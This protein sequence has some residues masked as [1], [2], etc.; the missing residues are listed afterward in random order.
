M[1]PRLGT[2]F[3]AIV[4]GAPIPAAFIACSNTP[5]A[6]DA[7]GVDADATLV[8]T[9]AASEDVTEDTYV[10]WC[11][12]GPPRQ[13]G[14]AGCDEFFYVPCGLP[15]GFSV[16]D[17]GVVNHCSLICVDASADDCAVLPP[18]WI[19]YFLDAGFIDAATADTVDAGAV[20][21]LCVCLSG[22]GR[23]PEGFRIRPARTTSALAGYFSQMARLEHAS[24][25]AFERMERELRGLAAPRSLLERTA[26]AAR[27]ERVHA[28]SMTRLARRFGGRVRLP[29]R[30]REL[31][32]RT[33]LAIAR[34]NLVEGCI[35][36]TYGALVMT[37]QAAHAKDAHVRRALTPIAL[38]ETRHAELSWAVAA[39]LDGALDPRARRRLGSIRST[40]IQRLSTELTDPP[41]E[42]VAVAGVPTAAQAQTM[43]SALGSTLWAT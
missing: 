32:P 22:G 3:R 29:S 42:L 7:G 2:L 17:S 21:V 9:D 19:D 20:F 26:R 33:A 34:E 28:Q 30:P 40:A 24:V 41:P 15:A 23:R 27:D 18:P 8:I 43:L 4:A 11:E 39:F 14:E 35:R 12:A 10:D 1:P 25:R 5:A 6:P 16:D 31:R 38:D 13:F 36:E 37:W